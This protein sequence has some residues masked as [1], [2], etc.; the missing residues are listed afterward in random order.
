MKYFED[1]NCLGFCQRV[2][3]V[4]YL[5]HLTGLFALTLKEKNI[6]VARNDIMF[7]VDAISQA[8]DMSNN[9]ENRFKGVNLDLEEYKPYLKSH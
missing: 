4:G 2:K 5:E 7:L 1:F 9:G 8:I 6:T 3:E